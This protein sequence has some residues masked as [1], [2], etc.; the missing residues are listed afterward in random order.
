MRANPLRPPGA[1]QAVETAKGPAL[2][3][4]RDAAQPSGEHALA[5]LNSVSL[6]PGGSRAGVYVKTT[7]AANV[8][9]LAETV[10]G[11]TIAA[12]WDGVF[13]PARVPADTI[14]KIQRAIHAALQCRKTT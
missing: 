12:G 9:T 3:P 7:P 4:V 10:P 6:N 1:L 5:D 13:A 14:V 8:P 11:F 2:K